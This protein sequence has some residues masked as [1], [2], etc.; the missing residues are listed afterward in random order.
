MNKKFIIILAIVVL[1]FALLYIFVVKKPDYYKL[2]IPFDD[3]SVMGIMY[4]GGSQEDYNY[5][6]VN[7]YFKTNEF[8]VIQLGG[9]EKYLVIPIKKQIDI[10]SLKLEEDGGQTEI[11][12]KSM[13]EP[14]YI[15]CNVSDIFSNSMLKTSKGSKQYSYS[16]YISLKDG[17]LVVED[18]VSNIEE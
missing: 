2:E 16:P 1:I 5:S 9:S 6:V 14:F 15:T 3:D 18:F 13:N 12:I 8:E 4:I 7:K 17:S 10:Y 11:F